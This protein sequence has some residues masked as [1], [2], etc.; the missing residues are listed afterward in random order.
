VATNAR[1]LEMTRVL[2]APR[3]VVFAAFRDA[4]RLAQ[5][6]G[7]EGFTV[8][9][10]DFSTITGEAYRIQMRPPEGDPFFVHGVFRTVHPA[11]RLAFTFA[12]EP[13]DPDDVE[14]LVDLSFEDRGETTQVA[15]WQGDFLTEAR[16]A[17]HRDGW[18]ESFVKLERLLSGGGSPP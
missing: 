5:W 4:E 18:G 14:T 3:P 10:I 2:P 7:P 9:S 16:L 1:I 17:L 11:A 6:W 8:P 12:W 15:L 13:P